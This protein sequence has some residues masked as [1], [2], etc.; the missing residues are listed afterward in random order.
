[1][2]PLFWLI[3]GWL[4]LSLAALM[5]ASTAQ[6]HILRSPGDWTF[7]YL[8]RS[9]T[10]N[11]GGGSGGSDPINVIMWQYGEGNRMNSHG[12]A[13]TDWGFYS[14]A[15]PRSD[16]WICGDSD[17][18]PG[19][20]TVNLE[21]NFDDQEGHGSY[22]NVNRAHFRIWFAPHPHSSLV[23]KWSAIDAHH[24]EVQLSTSIHQ[25]DED[26]EVWE[27]HFGAEMAPEHNFY[28]D[29][30][31]NRYEAYYQGWYDDGSITRVG[32]LHN[33]GY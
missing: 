28:Y 25:I 15:V 10:A 2:T 1:M 29:F 11:C 19:N 13:E 9:D 26:W 12:E 4:A 6:G 31:F 3:M 23:D 30:W 14:G 5:A 20:Y 8:S 32:G 21:R 22:Y 16:Q 27:Y 24:E 17:S 18:A 7:R 33:G